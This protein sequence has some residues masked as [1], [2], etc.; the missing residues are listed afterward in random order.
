MKEC[1]VYAITRRRLL[2][3]SVAAVLL[4][5]Y[6]HNCAGAEAAQL[7]PRYGASGKV[8]T[9]FENKTSEIHAVAILA[10]GEICVAGMAG[11]DFAVA[12]YNAN[13]SLDVSF[14]SGGKVTT[15]FTG[16]NGF[17]EA[18]AIAVQPDN[19]IIAVGHA[20]NG[21]A[22]DFALAR[23]NENGT[24]DST[25]GNGGRVVTNIGAV[26]LAHA[27]AL[28]SDGEILV[29]GVSDGNFTVARYGANGNL[30][31]NF[32]AA[33]SGDANAVVISPDGK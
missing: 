19:R 15:D 3:V 9:H 11:G 28:Q 22:S 26:D 18:D 25:F 30:D 33:G 32:A 10:N 8:A 5:S 31:L 7:D 1:A 29:A 20:A 27:A 23:Y 17:D 21:S 14:G 2:A 13:G 16:P 24:L 6:L 12:R 4:S